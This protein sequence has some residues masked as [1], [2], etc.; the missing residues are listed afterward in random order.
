MTAKAKTAVLC[1]HARG[2]RARAMPCTCQ[3]VRDAA[4]GQYEY[5]PRCSLADEIATL[6]VGIRICVPS[7]ST[8]CSSA[9]PV[10]EDNNSLMLSMVV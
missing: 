3:F 5:E 1:S 7:L 4:S 6:R 9:L 8:F 10:F 2:S